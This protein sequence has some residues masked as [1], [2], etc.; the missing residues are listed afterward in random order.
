MYTVVIW[1]N[2]RGAAVGKPW[3]VIEGRGM[4]RRVEA[5]QEVIPQPSVGEDALEYRVTSGKGDGPMGLAV[6]KSPVR[7]KLAFFVTHRG[8]RLCA[9][10]WLQ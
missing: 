7:A 9:R 10:A 8:C 3:G 5:A 1:L 4:A 2:R 6:R